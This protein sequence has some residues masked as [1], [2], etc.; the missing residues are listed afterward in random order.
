MKKFFFLPMLAAVAATVTFSSCKDENDDGNYNTPRYVFSIEDADK[1]LT[2]PAL[3]QEYT[4]AVTSTKNG[5]RIGFSVVEFPEWAPATADLTGLSINVEESL[6]REP[7]PGKVIIK[8]EE[9]EDLI[10]IDINQVEVVDKVTVPESATSKILQVLAIVPE[11]SG[12]NNL[13]Q[14]KW[15]CDAIDGK[16]SLLCETRNLYFI[17]TMEKD[18]NV[19][20]VIKDG[21]VTETKNI[22]VTASAPA[23]AYSTMISQV[24]EYKP[25][26]GWR[27]GTSGVVPGTAADT[28]ELMAEKCTKQ[29]KQNDSSKAI[30]LGDWGGYIIFGFDHAIIN[31]PGLRD[32]KITSST[33]KSNNTR[34]GVIMVSMDTNG[35]GLPDDEWYEIAG[36]EHMHVQT[37]HNISMTY[38]KPTVDTST[39]PQYGDPYLQWNDSRGNTGWILYKMPNMGAEAKYPMWYTNLNYPG[40][41]VSITFEG[42]TKLR[43]TIVMNGMYP[44]QYSD[45]NYNPFA[46]G[47]ACNQP[48]SNEKGTAID[49]SWAVDKLGNYVEL[50]AINFVKVYTGTFKDRG[51]MYGEADTDI[52]QA[53]DLHLMGKVIESAE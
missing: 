24:F 51:G 41:E 50:P 21:N 20:F 30:S 7:R 14:Y 13:P 12:Y 33:A 32:F 49:I 8:Q 6:L 5:T 27:V 31:K 4:I 29:F 45:A 2:P 43:S 19:K 37:W 47:Y 38:Y 18:Y 52:R 39:P 3:G 53:Y 42:L 17:P 40:S 34:P 23:E 48:D 28:K 9:S 44:D 15:T 16:D 46:Y 22:T 35:N 26:P 1:A 11:I 10:T 36:S 25:A